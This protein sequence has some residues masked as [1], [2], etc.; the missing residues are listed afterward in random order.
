M[1]CVIVDLVTDLTN[2]NVAVPIQG[3]TVVAKPTALPI[4]EGTTLREINNPERLSVTDSS[5]QWT[6]TLPWP[7]EQDPAST[8]W[9]L[10]MPNLSIWQ[11]PIPEG[12]AGP[13]TLNELKDLGWGLVSAGP[14]NATPTIAVQGAKGDTGAAGFLSGIEYNGAAQ[15]HRANINF[16]TPLSYLDESGPNRSTVGLSPSGVTPA[17]YTSANITVDTYGRVTAAAN[18]VSGTL[19]AYANGSR[20][21]PT[22]VP[23]RLIFNTTT[24]Q[25]NVSDGTDWRDTLGVLA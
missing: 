2:A 24:N 6:F 15:T 10:I 11:G 16:V 7:S 9:Q 22:T 18:G 12:N 20:P 1:P 8:E 23:Y 17:S 4:F 21:N 19:A 13:L 5:G 3:A 25:V 14:H